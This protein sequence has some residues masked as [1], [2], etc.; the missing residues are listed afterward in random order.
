MSISCD[1]AVSTQMAGW[2]TDNLE[3]YYTDEKRLQGV[4]GENAKKLF[5]DVDNE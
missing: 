2:F 3:K 1:Q 4:M 5:L